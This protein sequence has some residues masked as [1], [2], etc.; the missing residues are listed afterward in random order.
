MFKVTVQ[1]KSKF[2]KNAVHQTLCPLCQCILGSI[3]DFLVFV[4]CILQKL[5]LENC[6]ICGF[7]WKTN[8]RVLYLPS[9]E[10]STVETNLTN[11][12]EDLRAAKLGFVFC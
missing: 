9:L 7:K 4:P 2:P 10:T 6:N 8:R 12:T 11:T 3:Q 5:R 1:V